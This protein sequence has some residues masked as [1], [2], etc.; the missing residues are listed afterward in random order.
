MV[1]GNSVA[2]GTA[3]VFQSFAASTANAPLV[4][5]FLEYELQKHPFLLILIA[6]MLPLW[7]FCICGVEAM[8]A[9]EQ[10]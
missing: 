1:K 7:R 9:M 4:G 3:S 6:E 2:A 10:T 5:Q 8:V